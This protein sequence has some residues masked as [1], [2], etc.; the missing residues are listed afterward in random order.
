MILNMLSFRR[1]RPGRSANANADEASSGSADTGAVRAGSH[2]AADIL[3]IDGGLKFE[4]AQGGNSSL[5]SYQEVS[6]APVELSSP[7]GYSVGG[8]TVIFFNVGKMIG[9]GVYSTR[10]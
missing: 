4:V 6:G 3:S 7:L 9:T 2:G 10:M 8:A 1:F 5:P